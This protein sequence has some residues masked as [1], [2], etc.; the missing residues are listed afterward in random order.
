[1]T[2]SPK[3]QI[4]LGIPWLTKDFIGVTHRN[5]DEGLS[6][7]NFPVALLLKQRPSLPQY[8]TLP[9][10]NSTAHPPLRGAGTCI[11]SLSFPQEDDVTG[12]NLVTVLCE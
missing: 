3:K 4:Q 7:S 11:L 9:L 5:T 6:S 12:P 2:A 8:A 1:M 10:R